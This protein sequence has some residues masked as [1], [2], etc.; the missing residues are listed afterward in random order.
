MP[1]SRSRR[2]TRK[3]STLLPPGWKK[4]RDDVSGKS[5]YHNEFTHEKSWEKPDFNP[6]DLIEEHVDNE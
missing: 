2:K 1:V 4:Y 5:Y 3:S 6:L